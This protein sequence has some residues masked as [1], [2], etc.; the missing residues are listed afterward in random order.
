MRVL[1]RHPD[2]AHLTTPKPHQNPSPYTFFIVA[3]YVSPDNIETFLDILRKTSYAGVVAENEC[4]VLEVLHADDEPGVVRLVEGWTQSK[5]WCEQV[6]MKKPY[7]A[8]YLEKTEKMW[9]K[10]REYT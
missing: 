5:E 9:I 10:P 1:H 7:Y 2:F 8:P 4:F 3:I 6:Q